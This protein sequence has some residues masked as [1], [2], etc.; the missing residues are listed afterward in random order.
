VA[1]MKLY[2]YFTF[3]RLDVLRSGLIRFT[4]PHLFND[5]FELATTMGSVY[6]CGS[7]DKPLAGAPGQLDQIFSMMF[8]EMFRVTAQGIR[9]YFCE[10][11]GV[12]SLAERSDNLLMWAHYGDEHRGFV[13]ELDADHPFFDRRESSADRYRHLC[14]V[15]YP[16]DRPLV[17]MD[18]YNAI[19]GLLSK[20]REW[21]YEQEW[22]MFLPL[23]S[24]DRQ[25]ELE[26]TTIHLFAIPPECIL[27][28]IVGYEV[29]S[30]TAGRWRTS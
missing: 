23:D 28:V 29:I 2:K 4:Q 6:G 21:S 13:L 24:S 10:Q 26:G 5:P 17:A 19:D 12:L 18:E 22:R 25:V 3:D 11:I 15:A 8:D 1:T 27:S 16:D 9:G 14:K 30:N 7:P 20:S